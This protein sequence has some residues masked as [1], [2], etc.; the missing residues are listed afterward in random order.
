MINVLLVA[1]IIVV[2]FLLYNGKQSCLNKNLP[3]CSHYNSQMIQFLLMSSLA[4][5][6]MVASSMYANRY[7]RRLYNQYLQITSI[8]N[9][10]DAHPIAALDS[11]ASKMNKKL[12]MKGE[13]PPP[14]VIPV[15]VKTTTH[16]TADPLFIHSQGN[17]LNN[18]LMTTQGNNLKGRE[19]HQPVSMPH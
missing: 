5:L 18:P 1:S 9:G 13:V 19:T 11:E 10:E 4:T 17:N 7:Q 3:D 16:V 6:L 14:P 15:H 2:L 12:L 8:V